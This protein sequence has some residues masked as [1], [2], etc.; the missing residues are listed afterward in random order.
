MRVVWAYQAESDHFELKD[1]PF[2]LEVFRAC[3]LSWSKFAPTF[4][5][6]GYFDQRVMSFL[7]GK[8]IL[9]FFSEIHVVDFDEEIK[10]TYK[11]YLFSAP[12]MWSF[13][14]QTEPFF[15]C[16]TDVVLNY[17][18]SRW[19]KENQYWGVFYDHSDVNKI[20]VN[21]SKEN[22]LKL[23]LDLASTPYIQSFAN[24]TKSVNGCLFWFKDPRVA[25]LTGQLLLNVGNFVDTGNSP[26]SW[27][28]Y[29]EALLRN[30]VEFISK[31]EVQC[32]PQGSFKEYCNIFSKTEQDQYR[33][34]FKE[35]L[36]L[37]QWV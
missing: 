29:E 20:P 18:V 35:I 11:T 4:K 1:N 19:F 3:L 10:K 34:R 22:Y 7:S 25:Q 17:S 13:T 8:D 33:S 24:F 32:V 21:V 15:I 6:V 31:E 26:E 28:L 37:Q 36:N 14:Q 2:E 30:L 16:D 27:I 5:R 9:E 12:K 23:C